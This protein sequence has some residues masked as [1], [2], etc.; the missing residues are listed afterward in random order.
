MSNALKAKVQFG[1][2]LAILLVVQVYIWNIWELA[3]FENSDKKILLG[4]VVLFLQIP[5]LIIFLSAF[6]VLDEQ[7][8]ISKDSW[9]YKLVSAFTSTTEKTEDGRTI[10]KDNVPEYIRLCHP[11]WMLFS[12]I[13]CSAGVILLIILLISFIMNPSIPDLNFGESIS[14]GKI[15]LGTV[16]V[17]GFFLTLFVL[18]IFVEKIFPWFKNSLLGRLIAAGYDKTCVKIPI[19]TK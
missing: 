1:L 18:G 6:F 19:E 7:G 4:A 17:M 11:Y 3:R 8:R 16:V 12:L 2:L 13:A 10:Y 15:A 9:L 14:F 5:A